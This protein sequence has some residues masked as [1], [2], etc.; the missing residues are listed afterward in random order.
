[1]FGKGLSDHIVQD[2][3]KGDGNLLGWVNL[4]TSSVTEFNEL[5]KS[6]YNV[7]GIKK[8][9]NFEPISYVDLNEIQM[10]N[11]IKYTISLFRNFSN[12]QFTSVS[13]SLDL[14]ELSD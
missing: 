14:Q 11:N 6:L 2:I 8:S 10:S 13:K 9:I 4:D 3:S 12:Y 5:L 7:A 1:L